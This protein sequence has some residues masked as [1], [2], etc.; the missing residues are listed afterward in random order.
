MKSAIFIFAFIFSFQC[1]GQKVYAHNVLKVLCS[2]FFAGRGY[3]NDGVD[4]SASYIISEL[5]KI[6]VQNFP[7]QSYAQ[8]YSFDV[9]T[10]PHKIELILGENEAL[11]AGK[12][13]LVNPNSGKTVGEYI[14]IVIKPQNIQKQLQN[15][16]GSVNLKTI[17]VFDSRSISDADSIR[18][19]YRLAH[20]GNKNFPTILIS[21]AKLMYSVGRKQNRHAFITLQGDAYQPSKTIRLSIEPLFIKEFPNKNIIG[22]IPGKKKKKYIVLTG[23]F[24]HLGKMGQAIFPGANDNASGVAM[25]LS[26]AK[27]FTQQQPKY[28]LVFIFFSGE[29]AGLEGSKYFVKHPFF[30]LSK[31]RFLLN[32][33]ILGSA[34]QGITAVNGSL[35]KKHFKR[36][37]KL[38]QKGHFLPLVKPRGPTQNSDHYFF[39]QTGVP[40]F[41]IYA[42]GD[43][44]NYHD[45]NDTAENTNLKNF[46]QVMKL[47]VSF[48]KKL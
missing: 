33:D 27:V 47:F 10:F 11:I 26:L 22:F 30:E 12:D 13:Y 40:S 45:I 41:F 16:A 17:L 1:W 29:E 25:L 4:K 23:H 42:L 15:L 44:K 7:G 14:P 8:N 32:I 34:S 9:N 5:K 20:E 39:S 48:I 28:S 31:V 19:F 6:G 35:H 21:K 24:D 37:Q 36:L 18:Q 2:D 46:D 38:N 3:V 43:C